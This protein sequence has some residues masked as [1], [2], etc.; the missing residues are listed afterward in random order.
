MLHDAWISSARQYTPQILVTIASR[1]QRVA[2]KYAGMAYATQLKNAGVL[3][4]TMYLVA[5]AMGLAPCALGLGNA[6]R[7]CRLT[8]TDHL[9]EGS[10]AE[11]MIGTP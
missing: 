5:T 3:I 1:F 8:G 9:H 4:Q 11:F 7:F 10:I 2:W 6:E